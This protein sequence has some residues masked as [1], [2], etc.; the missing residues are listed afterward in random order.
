MLRSLCRPF[1]RWHRLSVL[2]PLF[3][4]AC[5][6]DPDI[7]VPD[8]RPTGLVDLATSTADLGPMP[9][10]KRVRWLPDV[11][12]P[13][14]QTLRGITSDLSGQV[15]VVGHGGVILRRT[16]TGCVQEPALD[17]AKPVTTNLYG[18]VSSGSDLYAVGE[19]G[20]VLRRATDKWQ[21]EGK[22]LAIPF[23]LFAVVSTTSGDLYAVGDAG[24]VLRKPMGGVW[25]RDSVNPALANA[26]FRA[27]AVG[28]LDELFAV[29]QGGT[30]ARR[31]GGMWTIDSIPI[32]VGD[33]G[34]FHSVIVTRE[35]VFAAGDY[36]RVLR[37]DVDKWHRESTVP[38]SGPDGH[39]LA[40]TAVG[41]DLVVVGATGLI[42]R[43]NGTTKAWTLE[44]SGTTATLSAV[45]STPSLRAVGALG[46]IVV[47]Q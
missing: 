44:D 5:L 34:N 25:A 3:W 26:N 8:F 42:Q 27:L 9:D 14:S 6:P 45:G 47:Q 13:T 15:F 33:R 10:A 41:A 43:R 46:T 32:D 39:L 22:D 20:V 31:S 29:G 19:A 4:T 35:S 1:R 38:V 37:R 11:N 17:G 21:Q 16:A 28:Q 2:L 23:S 36:D 40:M 7:R 18:V 24:T 12:A 30:I